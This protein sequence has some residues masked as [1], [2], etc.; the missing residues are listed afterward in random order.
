MKPLDFL[1]NHPWA[2][3][4]LN[5]VFKPHNIILVPTNKF[6]I[7]NLLNTNTKDKIPVE[8]KSG[9]YQINC[10]ECDKI[11]IGKTKMNLKTRTKEH[12]RNIK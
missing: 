3:N 4:K 10:K 8:N 2:F 6:S 9:V 1:Q 5:K 7:K 11:Y 12:F